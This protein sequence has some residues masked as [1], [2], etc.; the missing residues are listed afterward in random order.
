MGVSYDWIDGVMTGVNISR[1]Y[2][3]WDSGLAMNRNK[4]FCYAENGKVEEFLNGR[5]LKEP[6][7]FL[8]KILAY[9]KDDKLWNDRRPA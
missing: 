7:R 9:L 1:S 4:I 8:P 5:I 3:K 6:S 2:V